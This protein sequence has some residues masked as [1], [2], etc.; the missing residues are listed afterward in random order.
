M[1]KRPKYTLALRSEDAWR[2]N[3]KAGAI[4]A[5]FCDFE[6]PACLEFARYWEKEVE[7]FV[8][9]RVHYVIRLFPMNTACNTLVDRSSFERSC[10][11]ATIA[12]A[13]RM[14]GGNDA[15]WKMHD[16]LFRNQERPADKK[17]SPADLATICRLDV[18]RFERDRIGPEVRDRIQQDLSLAQQVGVT[19]AP[20]VFFKGRVMSSWN[21]DD[22]WMEL[23]KFQKGTISVP[24]T[25]TAPTGAR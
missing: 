23:L 16:E 15:F 11:S 24:L 12:E 19:S 8:A 1:Q 20:T 9:N 17:L 21:N 4:V 7:P 5:F 14:Q 6:S 22:L 10:E 25:T 18:A 3:R 13:A 2:D